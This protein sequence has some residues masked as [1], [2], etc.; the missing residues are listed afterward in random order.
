MES[1]AWI[2]VLIR[3]K[4]L[5]AEGIVSLI[6]A[7]TDGAELPLFE[8][9]AHIDLEI[10]PGVVRQYSLCNSPE[11]PTTYE[12]AVLREPVSRGGS[13]AVHDRLQVGQRV[14]ISTPRNHFRLDTGAS[15]SVLLA[16]GIG[17]TPILCMAQRL[18]GAGASYEL[19]YCARSAERMAYRER[20]SDGPCRAQASLHLD[21]GPTDQQLDLPAL[22]PR[23]APDTRLYVC[24]PGGFINAVLDTARAQGWSEGQLHREFFAAP[25][26]EGDDASDSTPFTV[27]L[28]SSGMEVPVP[29]DVTIVEAL[30][31]AGVFIPR[32]CSEGIC[33]TCVVHVLDGTP[34]HRDFVL[35]PDEH[36]RNDRLTTCCSRA[37]TPRL[38]L[39][40]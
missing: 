4:R 9:G 14:R 33:G 34:D 19:H 25:A 10:A 15:H 36:A 3:Q 11:G 26:A 37:K 31:E 16:G 32:S 13:Q 7:S 40:L 20:I 17:I 8:A 22:L 5:E 21:D 2:E 29:A 39:D 6:L 28:A 23:P 12:I 30:E 1:N 24:G 35:T 18:Q 27:V 38:V